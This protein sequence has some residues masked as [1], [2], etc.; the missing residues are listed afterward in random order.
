MTASI[1]PYIFTI[2]SVAMSDEKGSKESHKNAIQEVTDKMKA[3]QKTFTDELRDALDK[4]RKDIEKASKTRLNKARARQVPQTT[5][6]I[7]PS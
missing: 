5:K 7:Q 6:R 1:R 2:P 3:Y 4:M